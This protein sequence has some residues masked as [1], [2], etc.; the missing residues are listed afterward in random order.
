MCTCDMFL[1][2]RVFFAPKPS[3]YSISPQRKTRKIYHQ[4]PEIYYLLGLLTCFT[5]K[6][7]QTKNLKI[8]LLALTTSYQTQ[9][10]QYLH[11]ECPNTEPVMRQ[12]SACVSLMADI[13][14]RGC[15]GPAGCTG[16]WRSRRV[17][18][19]T[20]TAWPWCLWPSLTP[21]WTGTGG[22]HEP[23]NQFLHHYLKGKL[24]N[25]Q[26]CLFLCALGLFLLKGT[27]PFPTMYL[28]IGDHRELL[29]FHVA[30][31]LACSIKDLDCCCELLCLQVHK[32]GSGSR[33]GRVHCGRHRAIR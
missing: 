20:C 1:Q 4:K 21:Q 8:F 19:T 14:R 2:L 12:I 11:T 7:K 25:L 33:H 31:F 26:M 22:S 23:E 32:A 10:S 28:L 13:T 9:W 17:C 27:S 30:R 24:K 16:M 29:L 6:N 3:V 15:R 18:P 5:C